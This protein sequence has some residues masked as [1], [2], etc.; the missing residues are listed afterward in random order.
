MKKNG[1]KIDQYA[2]QN[3]PKNHLKVDQ[4]RKSDIV[5]PSFIF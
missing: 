1:T 4:S 3:D 2:S 5:W